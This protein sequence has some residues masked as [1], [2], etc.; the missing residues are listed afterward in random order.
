MSIPKSGTN[1]LKPVTEGADFQIKS[2][3]LPSI[4]GGVSVLKGWS[5]GIDSRAEV[6][7]KTAIKRRIGFRMNFIKVIRRNRPLGLNIRNLK[8]R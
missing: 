7:I 1:V 6:K 3:R 8:I 4:T 5:G 2:S